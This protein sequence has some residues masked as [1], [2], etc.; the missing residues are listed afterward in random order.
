MLIIQSSIQDKFRQEQQGMFGL[1]RT[2]VSGSIVPCIQVKVSDQVSRR[3]YPGE[4]PYNFARV[5]F[6]VIYQ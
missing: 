4:L 6:R 2:A 3:L 5:G 1:I